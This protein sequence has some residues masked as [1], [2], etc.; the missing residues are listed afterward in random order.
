MSSE[1]RAKLQRSIKN[2]IVISKE[3]FGTNY[4][5][6]NTACKFTNSES[7]DKNPESVN[8]SDEINTVNP[9]PSNASQKASKRLICHGIMI[10]LFPKG[11]NQKKRFPPFTRVWEMWTRVLSSHEREREVATVRK[12]RTGLVQTSWE[13][14]LVRCHLL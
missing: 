5:M 2:S 1:K 7:V 4:I 10:R 9:E 13:S 11:H 8:S 14:C 3:L 6:K 12:G